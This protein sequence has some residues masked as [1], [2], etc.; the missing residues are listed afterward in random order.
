MRLSAG[1]RSGTSGVQPLR[2]QPGA[3]ALVGTGFLIPACRHIGIAAL[4]HAA[5][6]IEQLAFG[7]DFL[8]LPA[9]GLADHFAGVPVQA[10]LHLTIHETVETGSK[11]NVATAHARILSNN[12]IKKC[13]QGSGQGTMPR[14]AEPPWRNKLAGVRDQEARSRTTL[15]CSPVKQITHSLSARPLNRDCR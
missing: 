9:E 10:C 3:R 1:S 2:F 4:D 14:E 13:C 12:G 11:G 15:V 5:E 8:L 7:G 6:H